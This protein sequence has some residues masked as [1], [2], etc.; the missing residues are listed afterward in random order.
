MQKS[1]GSRPSRHNF[2]DDDAGGEDELEQYA[3]DEKLGRQPGE[4]GSKYDA[5]AD[6]AE[7][8]RVTD[9]RN[10]GAN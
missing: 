8:W 2:E 7:L 5:Q 4:G 9:P 6:S 3:Y 10:R 1:R